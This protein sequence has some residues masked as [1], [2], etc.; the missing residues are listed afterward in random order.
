MRRPVEHL[1]PESFEKQVENQRGHLP[2]FTKNK[3]KKKLSFKI[4]YYRKIKLYKK[5]AKVDLFKKC[6]QSY[7]CERVTLL[8]NKFIFTMNLM[9]TTNH[10]NNK[11]KLIVFSSSS[12]SPFRLTLK[13]SK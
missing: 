7:Y 6:L 8:L 3:S 10:S 13:S 11:T 4:I 1:Y 12:C 5:F 2:N 9:A